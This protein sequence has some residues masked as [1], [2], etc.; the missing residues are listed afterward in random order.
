MTEPEEVPESAFS[1]QHYTVVRPSMRQPP[2]PD[3]G[4]EPCVNPQ[5]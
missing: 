2:P 5:D 1:D 4:N 3:V